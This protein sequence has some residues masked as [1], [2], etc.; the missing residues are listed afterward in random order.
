MIQMVI[1]TNPRMQV[2]RHQ[3]GDQITK[4]QKN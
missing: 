2:P 3:D 1:V 4:E